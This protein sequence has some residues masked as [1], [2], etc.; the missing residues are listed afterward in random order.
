MVPTERV[1]AAADAFAQNVNLFVLKLA[2]AGVESTTK[3]LPEF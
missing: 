2:T 1:V 3:S